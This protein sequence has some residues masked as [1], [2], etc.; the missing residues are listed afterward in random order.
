MQL[1]DTKRPKV[2]GRKFSWEDDDEEEALG[3][4]PAGGVTSPLVVK[5]VTLNTEEYIPKIPNIRRKPVPPTATG[6]HR[7]SVGSNSSGS[8]RPMVQSP[9]GLDMSRSSSVEPLLGSSGDSEVPPLPP[10]SPAR[11]RPSSEASFHSAPITQQPAPTVKSPSRNT[12]QTTQAQPKSPK[13]EPARGVIFRISSKYRRAGRPTGKPTGENPVSQS[14]E[15]MPEP[16]T[17]SGLKL[18]L[19]PSQPGGFKDSPKAGTPRKPSSDPGS[20]TKKREA[21]T[22]TAVTKA[23]KP[24][25]VSYTAM[26]DLK[27][28]SG[29][30]SITLTAPEAPRSRAGSVMGSSSS[31]EKRS[32]VR[33]RPRDVVPGPSSRKRH[34]EAVLSGILPPPPVVLRPSGTSTSEARR[35]IPEGDYSGGYLSAEAAQLGRRMSTRSRSSSTYS[36]EADLDG[37]PAASYVTPF[38]P[39]T[40]RSE[41]P[42]VL[43]IN[44]NLANPTRI[45]P[46]LVAKQPSVRRDQDQPLTSAEEQSSDLADILNSYLDEV[47]KDAIERGVMSTEL[48][49]YLKSPTIMD[50]WD[51][52]EWKKIG[53]KDDRRTSL[54]GMV[55]D[56]L[57][58]ENEFTPVK[59]GV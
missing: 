25:P 3:A 4:E 57:D 38:S 46:P 52:E 31:S 37:S 16:S 45:N 13:K 47:V 29:A 30:H 14:Q 50:E 5:K 22:K 42:A 19:P 17:S 55:R 40:V 32:M 7:L 1:A 8:S 54:V 48:E 36:Y 24:R 43:R 49:E 18:R 20:P 26:L 6:E 58:D 56:A 34:Q 35:L 33:G 9:G 15:K 21:P 2:T 11:S 53:E 59:W 10:K 28:H 44:T 27:C 23:D 51:N 39:N 12:P 41:K